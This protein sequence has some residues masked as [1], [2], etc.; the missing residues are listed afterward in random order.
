MQPQKPISVIG[1]SSVILSVLTPFIGC[2]WNTDLCDVEPLTFGLPSMPNPAS[3]FCIRMGGT[4][5]LESD[6]E[7]NESAVCALPDG[8]EQEEW[9][10]YCSQCPDSYWCIPVNDPNAILQVPS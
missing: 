3:V 9:A 5:R 10:F 8:A 2:C 6:P 7:G 4:L 1:L